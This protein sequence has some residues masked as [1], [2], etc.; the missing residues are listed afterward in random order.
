MVLIPEEQGDVYPPLLK[1]EFIYP[2]LEPFPEMK[3]VKRYLK[4]KNFPKPSPIQ[5]QCWPPLFA[6]KDTIGIASTG[7][8]KTLAFLIPGMQKICKANQLHHEGR[9][10]AK[11][12][13]IP[14]PK[15]LVL[16]PTRELAMQS[17]AVC[18]EL[19]GFKSICVFGG[20][21]KYEQKKGLRDGAEIVIGIPYNIAHRLYHYTYIS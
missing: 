10:S 13:G 4:D 6:G 9:S 5:S 17:H 14:A 7:S 3:V 8:G 18:I 19:G 1:F 11:T 20:M 12:G 21:P 15:L 2:S 16:A